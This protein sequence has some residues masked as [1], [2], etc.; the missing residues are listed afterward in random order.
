MN[1]ATAPDCT[2]LI[3]AMLVPAL[4]SPPTSQAQPINTA[5]PR[6]VVIGGAVEATLD[7]KS[8]QMADGSRYGCYAINT[9]PG[10]HLVV[11]LRSTAFDSRL[12][13]ARGAL[14]GAA[15]LQ[16]END[17]FESGKRGAQIA[18][19]AAG[20][21]Y[22]VMAAAKSGDAHGP[23]RLDV[24]SD[25]APAAANAKVG[26]ASTERRALMEVQ[27]AQRLAQ[28]E[29]EAAARKA[30]EEQRRLAA[31]QEQL[32]RREAE[33]R[34]AETFAAVLN[35]GVQAFTE[36][37]SQYEVDRAATDARNAALNAQVQAA[38]ERQEAATARALQLQQA[39]A[40]AQRQN[41]AEMLARQ[42]AEANAYRAR[43]IAR[44]ADPAER[45]RLAQQSE[46]ALRTARQLGV[47][48][49]V[50]RQTQQIL[51]DGR[52]ASVSAAQADAERLAR[53]RQYDQEQHSKLRQLIEQQRQADSR[54]QAKVEIA[55]GAAATA[56]QQTTP[57]TGSPVPAIGAG[58]SAG[59]QRSAT[60]AIGAFSNEW[61]HWYEYGSAD[62]VQVR[63]RGRVEGK[64]IRV[65]WSCNN[66]AATTR[67]CSIG[68]GGGTRYG[69]Y[70]EGAL[71]HTANNITGVTRVR[72]GEMAVVP[73]DVTCT[74]VGATFA[75]PDVLIGIR[76]IAGG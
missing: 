68:D 6:L 5:L 19:T 61:S 75:A 52:G 69:C 67:E 11:R 46:G 57:V 30:E 43:Q 63:W 22:L 36:T 54:R 44:T 18:F 12:L 7:A 37:Y 9:R 26:A 53:Q 20:G 3:I 51:A 71:V 16:F 64:N 48:N 41:N 65:Q 17:D 59:F 62:G 8:A 21:R 2:M 56:A 15:A 72:S 70:V 55:G 38:R 47:E 40:A 73:S 24:E 27:V 1:R 35:A 42:L 32:E 31:Q 33:Q 28:I 10:E 58:G 23:Y 34:R 29:V 76:P 50:S 60:P 66:R 74:G 25:A 39:Q 49:S 4:L 13:V 14:C 45:Q